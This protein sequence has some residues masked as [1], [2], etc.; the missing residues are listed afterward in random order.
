MKLSY[1]ILIQFLFISFVSSQNQNHDLFRS[2][3]GKVSFTSDAPLEIIKAESNELKGIIDPAN[4][5]FAFQLNVKSLKGFNSPLQQEHF[6]E[7]YLETEEFPTSSFS[8]K[9]IEKI[10]FDDAG[11]YDI[12]AKGDLNIH[13]VKQ[14]RIIKCKLDVN[15]NG[16]TVTSDFIVHIADHNISI[17]KLVY[18]KIA[19]DIKVELQADL[20]KTEKDQE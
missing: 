20:K 18:Q 12:R 1:F 14:E 8:G 10:N 19:E 4:Q 7:N 11:S 5:T 16:F 13:G 2:G 6:Y 3:K 15:E 9:I 17:P